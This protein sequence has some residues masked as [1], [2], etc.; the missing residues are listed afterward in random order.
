MSIFQPRPKNS[1]IINHFLT[2]LSFTSNLE[3]KDIQSILKGYT[4]TPRFYISS[5]HRR[6]YLKKNEEGVWY[7]TSKAKRR[8][9][10]MPF[11]MDS[12]RQTSGQRFH[13][14][15]LI[16]SLFLCLLHLDDTKIEVI[17]R[18]RRNQNNQIPDITIVT[19]T[20]T[21]YIEVDTGKQTVKTLQNKIKK[22][23]L[24]N[25]NH[26]SQVTVIYF[27]NSPNTFNEFQNSNLNFVFLKSPNLTQDLLS[28]NFKNSSTIS[29][30]DTSTTINNL[31]EEEMDRMLSEYRK[32]QGEE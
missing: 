28:I 23:E 8:I 13:E 7:L 31:D 10:S 30:T 22:Y 3:S 19:E 20:K 24:L 21:L 14:I 29:K 25:N 4:S 32:M 16:R 11:A 12:G 1:L 2:A 9:G 5:I 17:Y 15:L 18:Q 26:N 27:T 6:G